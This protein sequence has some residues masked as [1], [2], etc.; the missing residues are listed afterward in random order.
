MVV[1][2]QSSNSSVEK[3]AANASVTK[4][5]PET[6]RPPCIIAVGG[7][8]GGVG[9]TVLSTNIALALASRQHS[10][11]LVDLDLGGA[12]VHTVLG[13][14]PSKNTLSDFLLRQAQLDDVAIETMLPH[15]RFISGAFDDTYAANPQYSQKARLMRHLSSHHTAFVVLDLGAGTSLN[16]LDFFLLAKHGI[17]VA[18]PEPTSVENAFRFL[19]AAFW[20]RF[21]TFE[22]SDSMEAF[23]KKLRDEPKT[24]GNATPAELLRAVARHDSD[25]AARAGQHSA[26]FR[27]QLVLNQSKAHPNSPTGDESSIAHDMAATSRRFLGIHL[28]VLGVVPEDVRVRSSL[29]ERRPL[30]LAAPSSPARKAIDTLVEYLLVHDDNHAKPASP[31]H[32]QKAVSHET[33]L[34][35]TTTSKT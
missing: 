22:K 25:L 21:A 8:K 32:V 16:T 17:V 29:R 2:Q 31:E 4:T 20:R 3:T 35:T 33:P 7:G 27:P 19:K 11:L 34:Q 14:P 26:Q 18:L 5:T 6:R 23:L 12:N 1:G 15:L 30:Y 9:K 28:G 13:I 24:L 10:T